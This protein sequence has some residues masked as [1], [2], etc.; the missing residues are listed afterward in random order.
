MGIGPLSLQLA[1]LAIRLMTYTVRRILGGREGGTAFLAHNNRELL[2]GLTSGVLCVLQFKRFTCFY[3]Y[4]PGSV[5]TYHVSS[6]AHG[7]Q[8]TALAPPD[9]DFIKD[10]EHWALNLGPL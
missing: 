4:A 8:E 1:C 2:R 7:G 6:G 3:M 5:Y 9:L 10:C